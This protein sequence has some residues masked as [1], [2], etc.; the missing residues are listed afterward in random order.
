[1]ILTGF[2]LV[3]IMKIYMEMCTE[4][5]NKVFYYLENIENDFHVYSIEWDE[6]KVKGFVDDIQIFE[7]SRESDYSDWPYDESF[8]PHYKFSN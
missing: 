7:K 4:Q 8:F 5:I 3:C 1:M 2:I 6:F